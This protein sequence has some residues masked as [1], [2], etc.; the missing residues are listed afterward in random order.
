MAEV[1][2]KLTRV[3]IFYDGNFFFHVSNYYH[4]HHERRSRISISGLHAFIRQQV[5]ECEGTDARYCQIV[6][7][8]YFRGRLRAADAEDRDLLF[9]ERAFDDV[10]VREGVTTHYLPL[11]R[12]GEKGIDVWL[13]LE[14]FELAM[15]KRFNVSVLVACDG[16]FL[17][18]VRKLNTIGTRVMV[19]GWDF[20]YVDQNGTDRETRTA[21]VLLDEVT[22]PIMM[23]SIIEDRAR[24][25]DPLINRLF[26]PRKEFSLPTAPARP[27]VATS[28]GGTGPQ[29]GSIQSLKNGYGFINPDQVGPNMF[30]FH[31][32]VHDCDFLDLK[33]GDRV[34]YVLGENDRGPCAKQVRRLVGGS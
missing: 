34:Q 26:V 12:D 29:T 20:K 19:L 31:L 23:H 18:L 11:S 22:Y 1:D 14:A 16:D 6:D 2:S 8:H 28:A 9:K 13:A 25:K 24:Q 3:G 10:L 30:F 7:A 27:V 4:Y 17:P 15:Y 32:D 5:A 21:Q 33:I